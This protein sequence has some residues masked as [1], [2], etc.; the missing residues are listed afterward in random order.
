MMPEVNS[1][2]PPWEQ[3]RQ[4]RQSQGG[5]GN[6]GR[7]HLRGQRT[8]PY[9]RIEESEETPFVLQYDAS[10]N[11][12]TLIKTATGVW[13]AMYNATNHAVSFTSEDDA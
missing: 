2:E 6:S 13:T 5:A 3:S 9:T 10:G 1:L 7:T 4:H 12:K 11:Q 8:Q